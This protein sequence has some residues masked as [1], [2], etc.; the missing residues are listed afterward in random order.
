MHLQHS[1]QLIDALIQASENFGMMLYPGQ[2]HMSFFG[3]GQ[4]PTR[5]WA[6]ITAFFVKNLAALF[7]V[8]ALAGMVSACT[9]QAPAP[10]PDSASPAAAP[11]RT[12]GA[13]PFRAKLS[14]P[15]PGRGAPTEATAVAWRVG[16]PPP[17]P[18]AGE[19][20]RTLIMTQEHCTWDGFAIGGQAVVTSLM[21]GQGYMEGT[22]GN[23]SGYDWGTVANGDSY[24]SRWTEALSP[25]G[26]SGTWT[27]VFGTGSLQGLTGNATIDCTP[28]GQSDTVEVCNVA[29]AYTLPR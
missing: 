13:T 1:I 6:R 10:R 28:P 23:A 17:A 7:V 14:C 9:A 11:S 21:H 8:V 22:G 29:G 12:S 24:L 20:C 26:I 25:G 19:A 15:I 3:M 2:S 5:L 4:D 16:P 18:C 27:V